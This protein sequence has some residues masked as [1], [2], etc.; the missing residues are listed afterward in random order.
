[1]PSDPPPVRSDC[2]LC[3]P[4]I[5]PIVH[6]GRFW[7]TAVNHNQNLLG[8][9][10]IVLERHEEDVTLLGRDEWIELREEV[11]WAVARLRTAFGPDHFNFAFLQNQDRHVHLHVIP[12]YAAARHIADINFTDPDYPDMFLPGRTNIVHEHVLRAID[13]ALNTGAQRTEKARS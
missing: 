4:P 10:I 5:T 1:M 2:V 9:L 13:A 7:R 3:G 11:V 12:R 6:Q 8:K